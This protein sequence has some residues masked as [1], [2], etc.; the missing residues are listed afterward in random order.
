MS[1]LLRFMTRLNG[2][3]VSIATNKVTSFRRD[4]SKRIYVTTVCGTTWGMTPLHEKYSDHQY[5]VLTG[6]LRNDR[7]AV[8]SVVDIIQLK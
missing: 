6:A 5:E 3:S 4:T 1:S 7:D 8:F 2:V